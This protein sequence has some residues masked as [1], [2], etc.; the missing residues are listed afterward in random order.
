MRLEKSTKND[1]ID[2]RK[3][4]MTKWKSHLKSTKSGN[5]SSYY[6]K[7][8]KVIHGLIQ[9]VFSVGIPILGTLI[10]LGPNLI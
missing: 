8:W 2:F 1:N 7:N 5:G 9:A 10:W 6:S 3:K 4:T